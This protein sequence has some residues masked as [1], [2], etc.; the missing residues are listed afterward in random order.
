MVLPWHKTHQKGLN[1]AKELGAAL[2]E[3]MLLNILNILFQP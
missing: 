1:I 3:L 2:P